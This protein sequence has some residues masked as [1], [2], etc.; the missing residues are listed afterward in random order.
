MKSN[1]FNDILQ[2]VSEV[3]EV[4]PEDLLS[5]KRDSD[6]LQARTLLAWFCMDYGIC[7]KCI[8][9]FMQ[10]KKA[11]TIY[12]YRANFVLYKK[13]STSFRISFQEIS[14]IL[15]KKIPYTVP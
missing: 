3:C 7:V 12:A 14:N 6:I 13:M 11:S 15:S 9:R 10:R 5:Q 8:A 1:L 2:T 4:S